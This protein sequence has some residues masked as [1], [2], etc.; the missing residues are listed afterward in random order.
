MGKIRVLL[1]QRSDLPN[2]VLLIHPNLIFLVNRS[3]RT[4]PAGIPYIVKFSLTVNFVGL[5]RVEYG[6][7]PENSDPDPGN[8]I[9]VGI[10]NT[11]PSYLKEQVGLEKWDNFSLFKIFLWLFSVKPDPVY[12]VRSSPNPVFLSISAP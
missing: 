12:L 9:R 6:F 2:T 4:Q 8:M 3:A 7:R 11:A 1:F 5:I 10:R